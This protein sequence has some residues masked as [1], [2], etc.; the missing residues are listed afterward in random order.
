MQLASLGLPQDW[1]A[2]HA[3]NACH[4]VGSAVRQ[5]YTQSVQ[6]EW[7]AQCMMHYTCQL[8]V[9]RLNLNLQSHATI[10]VQAIHPWISLPQSVI[11]GWVTLMFA[12]CYRMYKCTPIKILQLS[13]WPM[14]PF[15]HQPTLWSSTPIQELAICLW[16]LGC[17]AI[18]NKFYCPV[19]SLCGLVRYKPVNAP[20]SKGKCTVGNH[21]Y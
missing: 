13:C 11:Y 19:L 10:G 2:S 15:H 3:L 1:L 8:S 21:K 16:R 5:I 18:V 17:Y 4:C 6:K 12:Q 9:T 14:I 7:N 20:P